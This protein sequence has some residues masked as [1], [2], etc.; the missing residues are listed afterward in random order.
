M[1]QRD[2]LVSECVLV[3]DIGKTNIK[4]QVLDNRLSPVFE[5]GKANSVLSASPYP[6]FDVDAIWH[7]LLSVIRDAAKV[8]NIAAI[9]VTTHGATAAVVDRN[10]P[11]NGLVLPLLD[12]ES[13]LPE[14][15]SAQYQRVRPGF[16]ETLSPNLPLGLNLGR[17]LF[18]LQGEFP[19]AFQ[20]ATN[21]LLYPQYWVWRLTGVACS[22]V[23]SLGCHTDLWNPRKRDY[24]SLVGSMGWGSLFAPIKAADET[25]GTVRHSICEQTGLNPNCRVTVGI[26]DSNASYL[27]Y[28]NRDT[29]KNFA[30]ISTGTWA[31][32]MASGVP[33]D[34][35]DEQRDMLANVDYRGRPVACARFMAGRD[36]ERICQQLGYTPDTPVTEKDI[37]DIIK[38]GAYAL[39]QFTP[40]SGPFPNREGLLSDGTD[41]IN[42][43]ALA[44]MYSALMLD[45]E[46]DILKAEGDIFIEGAFL[47]NRLLCRLLAS[48]RRD[49]TVYLSGDEAGTTKGGAVLA[50]FEE[51]MT[52]SLELCQPLTVTDL[53]LYQENWTAYLTQ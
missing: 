9:S 50:G 29:D 41:E 17:Q 47:R 51:F 49:Q 44:T 4:V 8:H 11:G 25:A 36:Y 30:V 1:S 18:W 26:H 40:G 24:S 5:R 37:A 6:H 23:T 39:P 14:S 13:E 35:L 42:G 53:Y 46:L 16:Q 12:Y 38:R 45:V 27:R 10:Q 31:I 20:K 48:L 15:R 2:Q 33:L 28:I 32:T 7:W 52:E 34:R 22:E 19:N 21:I 43:A 3:L